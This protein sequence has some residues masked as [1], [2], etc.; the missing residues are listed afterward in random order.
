[1]P[2]LCIRRYYVVLTWARDL[3]VQIVFIELLETL[4]SGKGDF[5][6]LQPFIIGPL[7]KTK[8]VTDFELIEL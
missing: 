7:V 3:I 1:M 2:N 4:R 8:T 6:F 5:L